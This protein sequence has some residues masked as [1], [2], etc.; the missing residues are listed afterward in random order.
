MPLWAN[1]LQ[2]V[3]GIKCTTP[4]IG[5]VVVVG[6]GWLGYDGITCATTVD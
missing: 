6:G 2:L 1:S 5:I 3:V 4:F